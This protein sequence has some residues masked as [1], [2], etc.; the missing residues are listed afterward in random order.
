MKPLNFNKDVKSCSVPSNISGNLSVSFFSWRHRSWSPPSSNCTLEWLL[1]RP[2]TCP[3]HYSVIIPSF[4][5]VIFSIFLVWISGLPTGMC[6][7]ISSK[8]YMGTD[9]FKGIIFQ[10]TNS[11][12]NVSLL[13]LICLWS[14]SRWLLFTTST[15]PIALFPLQ[16]K[17]MSLLVQ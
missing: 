7:R 1:S 4:L 10:I 3:S 9:S 8:R 2:A 11:H 13:R 6:G 5:D 12:M 16:K 17:S 14:S 15:F